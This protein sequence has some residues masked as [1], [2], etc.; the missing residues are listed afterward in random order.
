MQGVILGQD[1]TTQRVGLLL[2]PFMTTLKK[3]LL[4]PLIATLLIGFGFHP[5]KAVAGGTI[6]AGYRYGIGIKIHLKSY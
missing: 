1:C 2:L 3:L 5:K 4:A 6:T